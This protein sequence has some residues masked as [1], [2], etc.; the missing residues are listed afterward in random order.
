MQ[1]IL[2][3]YLMPNQSFYS[4]NIGHDDSGHE[5]TSVSALIL[6]FYHVAAG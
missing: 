1:G 4:A 3:K 5:E 2:A 6:I